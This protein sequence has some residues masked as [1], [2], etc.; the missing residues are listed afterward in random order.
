MAEHFAGTIAVGAVQDVEVPPGS[1]VR[2]THTTHLKAS[3]LYGT[4]SIPFYQ[5]IGE[6]SVPVETAPATIRLE[7]YDLPVFAVV[8]GADA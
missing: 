3:A 1:D 8:E 6:A 7:P 5:G 2:I 4:R